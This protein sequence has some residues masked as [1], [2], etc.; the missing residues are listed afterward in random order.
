M[1]NFQNYNNSNLNLYNQFDYQKNDYD[2]LKNNIQATIENLR[3]EL[4]PKKKDDYIQKLSIKNQYI[5][6]PQ[7]IYNSNSK[8][9]LNSM[10]N[11]NLLSIQ[12]RYIDKNENNLTFNV[13][14]N[15]NEIQ[16][17]DLKNFIIS[18]YPMYF[19]GKTS[20]DLIF[21][22]NNSKGFSIELNDDEII[23]KFNIQIE[24][25][26][27]EYC[28][29]FANNF[30]TKNDYK[31]NVKSNFPVITKFY[32]LPSINDL[33]LMPIEKLSKINHFTI[34]NN[35][36]KI[37]FLNDLNITNINFDNDII[38]KQG[39]IEINDNS[40]LHKAEAIISLYNIMPNGKNFEN[41]IKKYIEDMN[42]KF[43]Y[44]NN[45]TLIFK[46]N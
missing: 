2:I 31:N 19:Y 25:K 45:N 24:I 4:T 29:N 33:K 38:L 10:N 3:N 40:I 1:K 11:E 8:N 17:K 16:V 37:E 6:K 42:G 22:F 15:A 27:R 23:K 14:I 43:L 36:G 30:L 13:N 39:T 44:Y 46:F 18:E 12:L 21:Y 41:D 34:W 32:S 9:K 7:R 5:T 28:P 20:N 26:I 35:F